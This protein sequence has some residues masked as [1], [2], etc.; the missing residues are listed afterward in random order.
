MV[1][2][3][4]C[5]LVAARDEER[6]GGHRERADAAL[7]NGFEGRVDLTISTGPQDVKLQTNRARRLLHVS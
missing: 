5:E 2:R 7:R 6:I 1:R 4:G 3:Q